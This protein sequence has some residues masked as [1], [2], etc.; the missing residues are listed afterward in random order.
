[1]VCIKKLYFVQMR[2]VKI[3]LY[4][5]RGS[6]VRENGNYTTTQPQHFLAYGSSWCIFCSWGLPW[7]C[8]ASTDVVSGRSEV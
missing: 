6:R 2:H 3:Q 1:M 7:A 4:M 8:G 5:S